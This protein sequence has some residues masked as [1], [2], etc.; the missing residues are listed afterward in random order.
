MTATWNIYRI[1]LRAASVDGLAPLSCR[2]VVAP[3]WQSARA[4]ACRSA[5]IGPDRIIGGEVVRRNV[6]PPRDV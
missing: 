1:T 3:D 6:T 2:D 4:I 5:G